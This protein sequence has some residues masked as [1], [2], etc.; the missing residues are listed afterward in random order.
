MKKPQCLLELKNKIEQPKTQENVT[1]CMLVAGIVAPFALG[2]SLMIV[3]TF[4]QR[5]DLIS[6]GILGYAIA[7]FGALA[8]AFIAAL[9]IRQTNKRIQTYSWRRD[10]K[11]KDIETI[12]EPLYK[13][14]H[15]LVSITA[16]MAEFDF[17]RRLNWASI[18]DS[19][20]A[21]KLELTEPELYRKLKVLF[22]S[23]REYN[24]KLYSAMNMVEE[25]A[26]KVIEPHLGDSITD[27]TRNE[28]LKQMTDSFFYTNR[29]I[30]RGFLLRKS[31]REWSALNYD[32]DD[33][34]LITGAMRVGSEQKSVIV[35][36]AGLEAM[37]D[38]IY[39]KVQADKAIAEILDW[40]EPFANSAIEIQKELEDHILEPQLL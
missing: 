23:I 39:Q 33:E 3:P 5:D 19:F 36:Q 15:E 27:E 7:F 16:I 4:P 25:I 35:S 2:L 40:Y 8:V 13:D 1:V 20:L 24:A 32:G 14:V 9:T 17:Q 30:Y 37:L 18:S 6:A 29:W 28:L 10:Q 38:E 26:R 21:T 22:D 31:V 12:Y 34:Y 11:L